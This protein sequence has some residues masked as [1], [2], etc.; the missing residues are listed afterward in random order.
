LRSADRFPRMPA[1]PE[2]GNRENL[3][4][5]LLPLVRRALRNRTGLPALVGWVQRS[6]AVLDVSPPPDPE[7]AARGL[8]RLL[9][10][11]LLQQPGI[12]SGAETVCGP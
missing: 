10:N 1:G 5:R 4:A 3:E 6:L 8:T 11:V 9:C 7:Q 12:R 2:E